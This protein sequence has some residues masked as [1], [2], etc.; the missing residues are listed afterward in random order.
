MLHSILVLPCPT[1]RRLLFLQEQ[2]CGLDQPRTQ[3]AAV[4]SCWFEGS[5]TVQFV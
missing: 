1:Q 3:P 5:D 2:S 4:V